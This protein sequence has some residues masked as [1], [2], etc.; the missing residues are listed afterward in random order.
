[1][2]FC[3]LQQLENSLNIS[4]KT[5]LDRW[6]AS[7]VLMEQAYL[8]SRVRGVHLI[9]TPVIGACF[10][11]PQGYI[12][13]LNGISFLLYEIGLGK[14]NKLKGRRSNIVDV[15]PADYVCNF[16]LSV[17]WLGGNNHQIWNFSTSSMNALRLGRLI[18]ILE[19]YWNQNPLQSQK[20][21]ISVDI[22]EKESTYGIAKLRSRIPSFLWEKSAELFDLKAKKIELAK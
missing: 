2:A 22:Y 9:R 8:N 16:M 6:R 3:D 15:V 12:D 7:L 10:E 4:T 13:K 20:H 18:E 19:A 5:D 21:R 14:V 17:G 11:K 1:M